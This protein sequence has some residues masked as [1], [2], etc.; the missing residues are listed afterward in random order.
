MKN[1]MLEILKVSISLLKENCNCLDDYTPH[2]S[3]WVR[4]LFEE[5]IY[6]QVVFLLRHF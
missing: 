3:D 1:C 4:R 6:W 5:G 2:S